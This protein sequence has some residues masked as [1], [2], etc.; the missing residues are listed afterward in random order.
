MRRLKKELVVVYDQ[1]YN[2]LLGKIEYDSPVEGSLNLNKSWTNLSSLVSSWSENLV[3]KTEWVETDVDKWLKDKNIHSAIIESVEP[4]NG[5][6]LFSMY[7]MFESAP[8]AFYASLNK[9][10]QLTLRDLVYFSS[11][12][13]SLFS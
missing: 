7:K 12:L 9:K 13:R 4:C 2:F 1:V 11:E 10:S 8:E 3:D 5:K 6:L